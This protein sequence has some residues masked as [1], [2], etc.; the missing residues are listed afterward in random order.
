MT[1]GSLRQPD[2]TSYI[3]LID[4]FLHRVIP[5]EDF[6]LSYLRMVKSEERILGQPAYPILQELFE[7]AD[8]YVADAN[9]RTEPEDLDDDQLHSGARRARDALCEVGYP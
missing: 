1:I 9:M 3:E 2:I 7:D 6:Q 8:A 4:R 5:A